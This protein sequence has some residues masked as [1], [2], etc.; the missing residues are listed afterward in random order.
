MVV[1]SRSRRFGVKTQDCRT[2]FTA[3]RNTPLY[4]LKTPSYHV[5]MVLSARAFGLDTSAAERIFGYGHFVF[6]SAAQDSL[7][8]QL[9]VFFIVVAG[10]DDE[11]RFAAREN[12]HTPVTNV[13]QPA[14][15]PQATIDR[16]AVAP[17]RS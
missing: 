9:L 13:P 11:A 10:D 1:L 5:A 15:L 7:A 17:G 3:R 4:R 2:A 14:K 12:G 8:N 16:N 6:E